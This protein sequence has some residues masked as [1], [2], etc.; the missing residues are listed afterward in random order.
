MVI[1]VKLQVEAEQ[2]MIDEFK[3]VYHCQL[4]MAPKQEMY[5][6]FELQLN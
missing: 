1:R 3:G 5:V 4:N 2:R 6:F